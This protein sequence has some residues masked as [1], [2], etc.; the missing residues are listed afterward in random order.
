VVAGIGWG[1]EAGLS[2]EAVVM[3]PAFSGQLGL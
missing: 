1:G 3:C 2:G